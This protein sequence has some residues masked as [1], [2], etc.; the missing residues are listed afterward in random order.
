MPLLDLSMYNDHLLAV[1]EEGKMEGRL[2]KECLQEL[3]RDGRHLL[4]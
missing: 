1:W 2:S 3:C 4:V